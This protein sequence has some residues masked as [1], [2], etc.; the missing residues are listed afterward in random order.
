MQK[1]IWKQVV[2]ILLVFTVIFVGVGTQYTTVNASVSYMK[3]LG[4]KFGIKDG[5]EY[6]FTQKFA[7]VGITKLTGKITNITVKDANKEGYKKLTYTVTMKPQFR[8]TKSQVDKIYKSCWAKYDGDTFGEHMFFA[9]V[10]GVTGVDL[11]EENDYDVKVTSKETSKTKSK[12]FYGSQAWIEY[13]IVWQ[14]KVT[15]VYP[16][17]YKDLCVGFGGGNFVKEK[18]VDEKFWEGKKA[19]GKTNF[20][21]KGKKNSRWLKVSS[22]S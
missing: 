1:K 14:K 12:R 11:E 4:V 17:D 13:C 18:S 15:V 16:E 2:S 5:K 10:D 3:K 7:G 9:V 21:K 6:T 20:Y 19:F 8:P 22:L